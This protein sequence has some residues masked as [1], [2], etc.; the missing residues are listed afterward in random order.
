MKNIVLFT[1]FLCSSILLQAQDWEKYKA[2]NLSFI[3]YFPGEPVQSVQPV[4]TAIGPVDMHMVLLESTDGQNVVYAAIESIYPEESFTDTSD[5]FTSTVLN[6]ACDGAV[7]NVNGTKVYQKN[8]TFN[9]YP[10]RDLKIEVDDGFIYMSAILVKNVMY[11][12]QVITLKEDD[13]NELIEHFFN[14]FEIIQV[15]EN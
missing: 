8:M 5:E 7:Q 10:G 15:N 3:A 9:G 6:N 13:E 1:L 14:H 4:E 12:T 2:D 11:I